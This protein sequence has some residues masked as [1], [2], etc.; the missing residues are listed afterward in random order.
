MSNGIHLLRNKTPTSSRVSKVILS[1]GLNNR[2]MG[3]ADLLRRE[4]HTL[5]ETAEATFPLAQ[6]LVP[7]INHAGG[8]PD[9]IKSN[10]QT[11]KS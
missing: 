3:N 10:I 9:N 8:L 5:I 4:L 1:F 6:V 7:V 11:L 2:R